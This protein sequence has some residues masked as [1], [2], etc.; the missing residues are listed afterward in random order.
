MLGSIGI[1]EIR[2]FLVLVWVTAA[3]VVATF[4]LYKFRLRVAFGIVAS[5]GL[6]CLA[7]AVWA[8]IQFGD[9]F[10]CGKLHSESNSRTFKC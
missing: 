10:G 6:I 1:A 8:Y 9:L 7:L 5:F 3:A 2:T 4:V